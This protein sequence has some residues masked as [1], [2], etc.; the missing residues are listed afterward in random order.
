[1]CDCQEQVC[2]ELYLYANIQAASVFLHLIKCCIVL[3]CLTSTQKHFNWP[4]RLISKAYTLFCFCSYH[5]LPA[6]SVCQSRQF[7]RHSNF[8]HSCYSIQKAA[9]DQHREHR[10]EHHSASRHKHQSGHCHPD[11]CLWEWHW[12]P[13]HCSS[14]SVRSAWACCHPHVDCLG[15]LSSPCRLPGSA[16]IPM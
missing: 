12:H 5:S 2:A 3:L 9:A 14:A 10:P 1:M 15:L 4:Q 13:A 11:C 16:V 7:R 8:H 6:I